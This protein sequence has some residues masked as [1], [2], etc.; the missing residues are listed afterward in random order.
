[1]KIF[2]CGS[3]DFAADCLKHISSKVVIDLA[4][5]NAPKSAGRGLK[6][7]PTPVSA[8]AEELSIQYRTTDRLSSDDALLQFIAEASPDIILVIDFGQMIKE[9]VLSLPKYGCIN[10]HPSML[11]AYRGSAP[12]Q[13]A[14]IDGQSQT[15]VTIFKL[16]AGMDS[17]PLLAQEIID[18]DPEDD[19]MSLLAKAAKVGSDLLNKYICEVGPE[20][21]TLTPQSNDGVSF[22]PKIDKSEGRIRW[23][24][25]SEQL[26]DLIRALKY[27]PGTFTFYGGKR[28]RIYDA[29]PVHEEGE[30]SKMIS[31][32]DGLPVVGCG[33][34]AIKLLSVQAEGKKIQNAA[35]WYRGS[36]LNPGDSFD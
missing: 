9:P 27:S 29:V 28:L 34:G 15:A 30:P 31:A 23:D 3:G 25:S 13:R 20:N 35:E 26:I 18:I 32:A 21:W 24:R 33:N 36:R 8:A 11:P 14:I 7:T 5:T 17:G 6:L 4:I 22:A 1:M 12:L 16:D 19:Y 10:I 2:F